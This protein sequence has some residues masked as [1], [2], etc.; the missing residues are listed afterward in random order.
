LEEQR[1]RWSKSL[2]WKR[3]QWSYHGP[4]NQRIVGFLQLLLHISKRSECGANRTTPTYKECMPIKRWREFEQNAGQAI[5][6]VGTES[7]E[8][9]SYKRTKQKNSTLNSIVLWYRRVR[10]GEKFIEFLNSSHLSHSNVRLILNDIKQGTTQSK[11]A[12]ECALPW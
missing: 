2:Q 1:R 9:S 7:T 5:A 11:P 10:L 8:E 12:Q 4:G 6:T 3:L